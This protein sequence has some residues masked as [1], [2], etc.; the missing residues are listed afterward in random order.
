MSAPP[1]VRRAH[2]RH[3]MSSCGRPRHGTATARRCRRPFPRPSGRR[4]EWRRDVRSVCASAPRQPRTRGRLT[5]YCPAPTEKTTVAEDESDDA[6]HSCIRSGHARA[7]CRCAFSHSIKLRDVSGRNNTMRFVIA[8]VAAAKEYK[9]RNR[10]TRPRGGAPAAAIDHG[11]ETEKMALRLI[12][13]Q[14]NQAMSEMDTDGTIFVGKGTKPEF[15]TLAL[16]NRHGLVT[17][18]T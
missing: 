17:G 3:G 15:L 2:G 13:T 12:V 4:L 7:C 14:R 6:L 10:D 8:R 16:A 1:R 18:A 9:R 11:G 5:I